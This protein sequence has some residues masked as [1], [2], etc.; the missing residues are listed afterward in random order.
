MAADG[1]GHW[2]VHDFLTQT[3]APLTTPISMYGF[4][5]SSCFSA[6]TQKE[7]FQSPCFSCA[8]LSL[9]NH[10]PPDCCFSCKRLLQYSHFVHNIKHHT[11]N[12]IRFF[13]SHHIAKHVIIS[14][15]GSIKR[16]RT[17]WQRWRETLLLSVIRWMPV[18]LS[19]V[20]TA[21]FSRTYSRSSL[22]F[23]ESHGSYSPSCG[24]LCGLVPNS[25]QE[26]QAE[27]T[28]QLLCLLMSSHKNTLS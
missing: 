4:H 18:F 17:H 14:P 10:S 2:Y 25:H 3:G 23:L 19:A 22:R 5:Q 27:A 1:T 13:I 8:T 9:A 24:T 7:I 15:R 21:H 28:H 20:R 12:G 6:L 26:H 11:K 16:L